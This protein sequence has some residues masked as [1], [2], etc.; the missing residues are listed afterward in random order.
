MLFANVYLYSLEALWDHMGW[1]TISAM[2]LPLLC[3]YLHM[4]TL[5][6]SVPKKE[7]DDSGCIF[8]S[9]QEH[10]CRGLRT[11]RLSKGYCVNKW[12]RAIILGQRVQGKTHQRHSGKSNIQRTGTVMAEMTQFEL[13]LKS[14]HNALGCQ[15]QTIACCFCCALAWID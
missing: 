10:S 1:A 11:F 2:S 6:S 9:N 14:W 3:L 4:Q 8:L 5:G 15:R 13:C 12:S 7:S